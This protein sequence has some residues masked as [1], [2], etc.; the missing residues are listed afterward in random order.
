MIPKKPVRL[1]SNAWN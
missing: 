1:R